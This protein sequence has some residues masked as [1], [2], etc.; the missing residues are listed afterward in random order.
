MRIVNLIENTEGGSGCAYAHGLSFY[1]ETE[2]HK[3]L[4]DAGPSDI[5]LQ[6]AAR[7]GIDLSKVDSLILSH[8][9]YDHS[10]GIIPFAGLNPNAAIYMQSLANGQYYADDGKDK[11]EDRFRYIGI[12]KEIMNLPNLRLVD[13]DME[14]DDQLSLFRVKSRSHKLPS[15]N[16]RLLIRDGQ[17][18]MSD[19][20]KHEHYLVIKDGDKRILIS[21]CAH[22]GILS[23]MDEFYS[24]YGKDP[25][26]VISGFHLMKKSPYTDDEIGE[27]IDIAKAL[28]KYNTKFYTCHCTGTDAYKIMK[29]L[30]GDQL[31]YVHSGDEV[32]L[33]YPDNKKVFC[34][35]SFKP[36]K[37]KK[38]FDKKTCGRKIKNKRPVSKKKST[39]MK[40]HKFFAWATLICFLMT[41][42]TGY[43]KR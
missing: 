3:L 39:F 6:N 30:M 37:C 15:S 11:G 23:I 36:I 34:M 31:E 13:G 20:F 32:N 41:V 8:G 1:V 28:K 14:I 35:D 7:L 38:N 19:D 10:G 9:H 4:V 25:D 43:K 2:K 26:V 24:K 16:K 29:N 21:G 42:I 27:I 33:I 18:Y 22:N 40:W 17:I 5:T 12:D